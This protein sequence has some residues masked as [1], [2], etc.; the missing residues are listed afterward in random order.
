MKKIILIFTFALSLFSLVAC[1]GAI[2]APANFRIDG[3]TA[4]WD[5]V[6]GATKY[7]LEFVGESTQKRVVNETSVELD[8]LSL[9]FGTY[10]VNVR[11]I[12]DKGEGELTT[13]NLTY[14]CVDDSEKISSLA[15]NAMTDGRFVLYR[16]EDQSKGSSQKGLEL[17]V[18]DYETGKKR[19]VKT[20]S[21]GETFKAALSLALGLADAIENKVGHISIETLFIDE[22]FGTLDDKSLHQA[23]DILL[24]LNDGTKSIGI[25]SHVQELKDIIP[26]KLVVTKSTDGSKVKIVS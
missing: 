8:S 25:I 3:D 23:I 26:T 5:S 15:G 9:P 11:A 6:E 24:E 21:G 12:T 2:N 13:D 7:R 17:E 20:L 22:G 19:D 10:T 16:K 14:E 18:F 1:G 4:S